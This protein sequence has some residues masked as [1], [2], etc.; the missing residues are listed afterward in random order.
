MKKSNLPACQQP[1]AAGQFFGAA[2]MQ[3]RS[4]DFV[5]TAVTHARERSVPSHVHA[6]PFFSMLVSG[7]YREWFGRQHWDARPLGIVLRP[8]QAEHH[9]EI[10][11]GGAVFLCVDVAPDYWNRL[12]QAGIRFERR[13]F[14]SRPLSWSALRLLGELYRRRPGWKSSAETLVTELVDEYS[15]DGRPPGQ[16]EP[17]WLRRALERLHEEPLTASLT[18]IARELDLHP[19][20]V[21]RMFRRHLGTTLSRYQKSLRLHLATRAVLENAEPLAGVALDHG[22]ADQSHLTR[23]MQRAT[24]WTPARLRCACERLR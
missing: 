15:A 11:P 21:T 9:D 7:R 4:G 19:V 5:V 20:H 1:L 12:A 23:A 18:G 2:Q 10:G 8:P 3:F 17:R 6:H 24:S 13:A 14:D 22:Y 16:R